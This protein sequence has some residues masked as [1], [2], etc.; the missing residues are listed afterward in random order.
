MTRRR[1]IVL[2]SRPGSDVWHPSDCFDCY[3]E[4]T[5]FVRECKLDCGLVHR[6]IQIDTQPLPRPPEDV[7]EA[8][9][10]NA[11]WERPMPVTRYDDGPERVRYHDTFWRQD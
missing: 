9:I 2:Y 7:T 4:A 10:R 5:E 1:W 3:G 11:G 8:T 6:V